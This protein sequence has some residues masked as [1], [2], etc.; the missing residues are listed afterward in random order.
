MRERSALLPRLQAGQPVI[1]PRWRLGGHRIPTPADVAM[2]TDRTI[3][4]FKV[5]SDD[6]VTPS[7]ELAA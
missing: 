3:R 6:V 4:W 1:V 5:S 2:F 7:G